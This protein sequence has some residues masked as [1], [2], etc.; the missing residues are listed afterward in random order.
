MLSKGRRRSAGDIQELEQ[1]LELIHGISQNSLEIHRTFSADPAVRI[2]EKWKPHLYRWNATE[3]SGNGGKSAR[4]TIEMVSQERWTAMVVNITDKWRATSTL[5]G[6][7]DMRSSTTPAST[8]SQLHAK[9]GMWSAL[10]TKGRDSGISL[11]E[12]LQDKVSSRPMIIRPHGSSS[13]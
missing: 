12:F 5:L 8:S 2:P 11:V 1:Y 13:C 6:R 7:K 4:A 3:V 9:G 10:I